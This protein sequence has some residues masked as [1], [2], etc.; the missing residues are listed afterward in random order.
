MPYARGASLDDAVSRR[1]ILKRKD[2]PSTGQRAAAERQMDETNYRHVLRDSFKVA[3]EPAEKSL[4]VLLQKPILANLED[5]EVPFV[6]FEINDVPPHGF[7]ELHVEYVVEGELEIP[8][9]EA[10]RAEL[11]GLNTTEIEHD[12]IVNWFAD[13]WAAVGGPSVFSPAFCQFHWGTGV[14]AFDLE[15]RVWVEEY[16]PDSRED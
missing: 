9:D 12:V 7:F 13:R 8:F 11:S 4:A 3:I 1:G 2:A 14:Y 15:A 10:E 5:Y 16:P 6:L